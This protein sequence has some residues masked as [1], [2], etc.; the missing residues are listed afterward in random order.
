VPRFHEGGDGFYHLSAGP[1]GAQEIKIRPYTVARAMEDPEV[2]KRMGP[3]LG[4]EMEAI[5]TP[6][7]AAALSLTE[8]LNRLGEYGVH[9]SRAEFLTSVEGRINAWDISYLWRRRIRR[10]LGPHDTDFLGLAAC[11]LW[12]RW[13][14]ETPSIE[15]IDDW[16][17]EGYRMASPA[18]VGRKCDLWIRVWDTLRGRFTRDMRVLDDTEAVFSGTQ[19][20]FNWVQDLSV[21]I[22]NAALGDPRYAL[23][24]IRFM[25]EFLDQFPDEHAHLILNFRCDL[26][27]LHF[28]LG[29]DMEGERLFLEIIEEF[30]DRPEGYIRLSDALTS[31]RRHASGAVDCDRAIQVLEMALSYPVVDA[32]DYDVGARLEYLRRRREAD[33]RGPG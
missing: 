23:L 1:G 5:W 9:V 8:I 4:R 18:E 14:P 15:M 7:R 25:R 11:E 27:D 3:L 26:A 31:S 13:C 6:K 17:Q 24:G 16:M 33:K 12:K 2:I 20:L 28:Y 21:E 19:S 29:G 10:G 30:P 32:D 22:L